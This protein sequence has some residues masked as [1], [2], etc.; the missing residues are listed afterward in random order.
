MLMEMLIIILTSFIYLVVH[1]AWI[2]SIFVDILQ[3]FLLLIMVTFI[4]NYLFI[5]LIL[6]QV[7]DVFSYRAILIILFISIVIVVIIT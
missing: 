7:K 2:L 4:A 5:W 6:L 3:Y 1:Y